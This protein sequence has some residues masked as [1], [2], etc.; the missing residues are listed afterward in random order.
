MKQ[1][2]HLTPSCFGKVFPAC[3]VVFDH[4]TTDHGDYVGQKPK[5]HTSLLFFGWSD[6]DYTYFV[7]AIINIKSPRL[8]NI[9]IHFHASDLVKFSPHDQ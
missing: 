7:E 6:Q 1:F 2:S 5:S 4:Q 8:M 3:L 9:T